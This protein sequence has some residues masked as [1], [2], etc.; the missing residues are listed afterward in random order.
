MDDEEFQA[1]WASLSPQEQDQVLYSVEMQSINQLPGS[2]NQMQPE[3]GPEQYDLLGFGGGLPQEI[4]KY[5]QQ[6]PWGMDQEAQATSLQRNRNSML[7]DNVTAALSGPGSYDMG[8]FQDKVTMPD[9]VLD[10]PGFR[11]AKT[12][13]SM[14]GGYESFIAQMMLN[15]MSPSQ[16]VAEMWAFLDEPE[17]DQVDPESSAMR[18]ALRGSLPTARGEPSLMPP[19][20]GV[21]GRESRGMFDEVA[22]NNFA[23][24]LFK[25]LVSDPELG[26]GWTDPQTGVTYTKPPE[27]ERS[28]AAS[29]YDQRGLPT[30]D[31]SYMDLEYLQGLGFGTDEATARGRAEGKARAETNYDTA[32]G[33]A[34]KAA[35]TQRTLEAGFAN[36]GP[37]APLPQVSDHPG[38]QR[39]VGES[40][41]YPLVQR[42]TATGGVGL[43]AGQG[44]QP[45]L[46]N[47]LLRGERR[48]S[49]ADLTQARGNTQR[50]KQGRN[51]ALQ[52]QIAE[53]ERVIPQEVQSAAALGQATALTRSGR[54]P[55]NDA[56]MQRLLGSR[57]QGLY[58]R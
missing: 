19:G 41:Q 5:G 21:K 39:I 8:A 31:E 26:T 10:Q 23:G 48:G 24:D 28:E 40:R 17:S 54:N 34:N 49:P 51:Q 14:A 25:Q 47:Y 57:A 1:W 27:T 46:L 33:G 42:N 30:P 16:A 43:A 7:V 44:A 45:N 18:E 3:I 35:G 13:A 58:R 15:G 56:L 50:A 38:A 52:A 12:Y 55:L 2:F 53:K 20:S 29:W 22:V 37:N 9:E 4:D 6:L 11:T 32:I 36:R